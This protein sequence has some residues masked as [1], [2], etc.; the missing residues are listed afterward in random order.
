[1]REAIGIDIGR[2]PILG[3]R[4]GIKGDLQERLEMELPLDAP[5]AHAVH[6]LRKLVRKLSRHSAGVSGICLGTPGRVDHL[7]GVCHFSPNF[8]FWKEVDL[9]TPFRE[10]FNVPVFAMNDVK[11]AALGEMYY[12]AGTV[13]DR[14]GN[15][16]ILSSTEKFIFDSSEVRRQK[17]IRSLV[18][19]AVGMGIG[20]GILLN[21]EL[22]LGK[23][24]AAGELGHLTVEPLGPLCGCGNR[25]CLE[26]LSSLAALRRK[27]A[28]C[29]ERNWDSALGDYVG[30]PEDITFGLL[31]LCAQKG[32]EV[33]LEVVS[34]AGKYLGI[35]IAAVANMFDPELIVLGG[36]I[37][38]L[39]E[40][41]LPFLARELEERVK[42]IPPGEIRISPARLGE[43]SGAF[44]AAAC[45]FR[46]LFNL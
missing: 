16:A 25:G 36:D 35:G 8:P 44:G 43:L 3:I 42:L 6:E 18:L 29:M 33:A 27:A 19:I 7:R 5:F 31:D 26:A 34:H 38:P 28:A 10:E 39:Y 9:V 15:P 40:T 12:G 23:H 4:T 13:E 45:V 11:C 22:V 30:A 37:V 21:G 46:N 41:L 20:S 17:D 2:S 24:Y 14:A 1:M 32:D